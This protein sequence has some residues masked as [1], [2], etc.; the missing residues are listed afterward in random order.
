MD[1][2]L[3]VLET[4]IRPRPHESGYKKICGFKDVRIGVDMA[5]TYVG[6]HF[7]KKR[8]GGQSRERL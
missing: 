1:T 7:E 5:K 4:R 6:R 8:H 3:N 2:K